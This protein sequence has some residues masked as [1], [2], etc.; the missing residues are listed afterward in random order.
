MTVLVT[1]N[2]GY[3]GQWVVDRLYGKDVVGLDLGLFDSDDA[4][5][6]EVQMYRD[7]RRPAL[8][9]FAGVNTVV[10]LAGLSND[11]SG[12]I[13][14]DLTN[15]INTIGTINLIRQYPK[16]L[17]VIASSCAVYGSNPEEVDEISPPN[18][19]T[20]YA[21]SKAAV[22]GYVLKRE[23]FGDHAACVSLRFGTLYGF[24]PAHRLDLVVNKMVADAVNRDRT[25]SVTGNAWRPHTHV[26][27]AAD[28]IMAVLQ[29]PPTT[30]GIYNVVGEN[31]RITE[32]AHDVAEFTGAA[33][34]SYPSGADRRDYRVNGDKFRRRFGWRPQ[35]T[36]AGTIPV[37]AERTLALPRDREYRR[38]PIIQQ[39][40]EAGLLHLEYGDAAA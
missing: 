10:H 8:W 35:H 6:P 21:K 33:I 34:L 23:L 5:V 32:V 26:E 1:G 2:L 40:I 7:I 39:Q 14:P 38:L 20:A 15:E 24:A 36:V 25:V 12:D 28:A 37:L 9:P 4:V 13:D 27:D 31:L 17:H 19:L 18:P 16:A 11:P 30:S 3:L 22:D 29:S